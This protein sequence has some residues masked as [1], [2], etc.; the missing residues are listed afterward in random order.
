MTFKNS[1]KDRWSPVWLRTGPR[2]HHCCLLAVS[3]SKEKFKWAAPFTPISINHIL[4]L[5][6][7]WRSST[8]PAATA[9][10]SGREWTRTLFLCEYFVST[11]GPAPVAVLPC[12]RHLFFPPLQWLRC[13][14]HTYSCEKGR[15]QL[16]TR[17]AP[18]SSL[19]IPL[20]SGM[21]DCVGLQSG[22]HSN[23]FLF[24]KR[25]MI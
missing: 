24:F 12:G 1:I 7:I 22:L 8:W 10:L 20:L 5:P 18:S 2:L 13:Q 3:A 15:C 23:W 25:Y 21:S 19:I 16:L 11:S 17:A 14:S 9:A 6:W 4:I